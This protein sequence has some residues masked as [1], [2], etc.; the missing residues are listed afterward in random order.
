MPQTI[1]RQELHFEPHAAHLEP[2]V[3]LRE[4][5]VALR[6][7]QV[8]RQEQVARQDG[9]FHPPCDKCGCDG[10]AQNWPLFNEEPGDQEILTA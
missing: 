10:R 1:W 5:Q 8:T 9:Y 4:P 7:A 2:H 3:A 6:E